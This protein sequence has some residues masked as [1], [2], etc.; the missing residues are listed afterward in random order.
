M[1]LSQPRHFANFVD[2]LLHQLTLTMLSPFPLE[3]PTQKQ[4]YN[5]GQVLWSWPQEEGSH[6]CIGC[7]D[8][9]C[10]A[11]RSKRLNPFFDIYNDLTVSYEPDLRSD[12]TPALKTHDDLLRIFQVLKNMPDVARV[13][14]TSSFFPEQNKGKLPPMLEQERG[15][16]LA[17]RIMFMINCS[18]QHQSFGLLEHGLD[19]AEWRNDSTFVQFMTDIFPMSDHPG[20][21]NEDESLSFDMKAS[22][23]ARKLKK[24]AGIKFRPT[25]DLRSHLKLDQKLGVVEIF[26]HT[27]FLKEHLRLTKDAPRDISVGDCLKRW[28]LI[29][30]HY[31]NRLIL[32]SPC[33][34]SW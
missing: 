33:S 30:L 32:L 5:L 26:H 19:K 1:C 34:T 28:F 27:A 8:E 16:N 12:E 6:N 2:F 22:I 18:A 10:L 14:F 20:I 11:R 4:L 9:G 7:I 21:N 29:S 31:I 23:M 13:D 25:N 15:V 3:K 17:V 24:V